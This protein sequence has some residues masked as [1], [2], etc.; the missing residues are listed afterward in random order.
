MK[1][2]LMLSL[3]IGMMLAIVGKALATVEPPQ[4]ITDEFN[5]KYGDFE[6]IKLL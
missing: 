5:S 4:I 3:V 6:Q 1:K 2:V